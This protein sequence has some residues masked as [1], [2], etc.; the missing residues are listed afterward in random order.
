MID[1]S[2]GLKHK[3]SYWLKSCALGK[4]TE[5]IPNMEKPCFLLTNWGKNMNFVAM[6]NYL[7]YQ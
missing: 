4:K 7:V 6:Q 5:N 2:L 1:L 3:V